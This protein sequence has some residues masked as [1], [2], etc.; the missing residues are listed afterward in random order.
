MR[1]IT[2]ASWKDELILRVFVELELPLTVER[3]EKTLRER[4]LPQA[5]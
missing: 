4:D 5:F 1:K 2:R 3:K